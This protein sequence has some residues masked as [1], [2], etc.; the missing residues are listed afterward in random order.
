M[1]D[2]KIADSLLQVHR[3]QYNRTNTP[4]AILPV[5]HFMCSVIVMR[6]A[7]LM[8]AHRQQ[9]LAGSLATH[10]ALL[11]ACSAIIISDGGMSDPSGLPD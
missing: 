2:A 8:P 6:L 1:F 9:M 5:T 10:G 3:W 11:S 7:R 4:S